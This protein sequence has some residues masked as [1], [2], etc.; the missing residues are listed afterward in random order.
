[1]WARHPFCPNWCRQ[2]S[3][4]RSRN[5]YRM[6][7][8]CRA[9][10]SDLVGCNLRRERATGIKKKRKNGT[11]RACSAAKHGS[12]KHTHTRH[13]VHV[14]GSTCVRT[15]IPSFFNLYRHRDLHQIAQKDACVGICSLF[16]S[17]IISHVLCACVRQTYRLLAAA[18]TFRLLLHGLTFS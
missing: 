14:Y 1:M 6:L 17:L 3:E 12:G 18:F 15:Y 8:G 7:T 13:I 2:P 5:C 11:E 9:C 10:W 4:V 16:I